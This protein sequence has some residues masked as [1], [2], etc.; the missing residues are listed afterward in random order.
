MN[1]EVKKDLGRR[2]SKGRIMLCIFR[3]T[4]RMM[5]LELTWEEVE[6]NR[7]RDVG[8]GQI[9]NTLL[10]HNKYFLFSYCK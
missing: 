1:N 6:S 3:A 8:K 5:L 9:L 10:G 7:C 4:G 2:N